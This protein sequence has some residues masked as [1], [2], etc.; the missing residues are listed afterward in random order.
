M[1]KVIKAIAASYKALPINCPERHKAF[2]IVYNQTEVGGVP[3]N[4][5]PAGKRVTGQVLEALGYS[6]L[7]PT[8]ASINGDLD[9]L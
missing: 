8:M 2:G 4:Q 5:H 3:L 1:S 9:D 6:P 7:E